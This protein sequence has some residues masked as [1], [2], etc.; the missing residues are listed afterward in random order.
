MVDI[1]WEGIPNWIQAGSAVLTLAAAIFAGVYAGKAAHWTKKQAESS[2]EQVRIAEDALTVAKSDADAA[3]LIAD[4]QREE[5]ELAYRRV[6]ES[7]LDDLA[8]TIF[9]LARPRV[10][11]PLETRYRLEDGRWTPWLPHQEVESFEQDQNLDVEFQFRFEITFRNTSGV[12]AR[13]DVVDL[14]KGSLGLAPGRPIVLPPDEER[15]FVWTRRFTP[16]MLSSQEEIDDPQNWLF[17]L[18]F[19]ARDIGMNVRDIYK[20][21]GDLRVFARDGSRLVVRPHP[22]HRWDMEVA[23][24]MRERFYERIVAEELEKQAGA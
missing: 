3:R 14:S 9:A 6:V 5:A 22:E 13:V 8:P 17:S 16:V 2:K 18:T 24:P 23:V 15:S 7:R 11:Q 1:G 10:S 21:N 4:R 19:W 12:I 20:F